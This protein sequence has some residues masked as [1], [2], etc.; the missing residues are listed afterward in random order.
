MGPFAG[1][2]S[3][4]PFSATD[5]DGEQQGQRGNESGKVEIGVL[6]GRICTSGSAAVDEG[7]GASAEVAERGL[8]RVD[9]GSLEILDLCVSFLLLFG[10]LISDLDV[11]KPNLTPSTS[12]QHSTISAPRNGVSVCSDTSSLPLD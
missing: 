9:V 10:F 6:V 11:D 12:H 2:S 3:T 4:A 5:A 8:G 7:A 1:G